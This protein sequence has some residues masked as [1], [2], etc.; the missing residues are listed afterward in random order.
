MYRRVAIACE[1]STTN[2]EKI[3]DPLCR[4]TQVRS[5]VN[6]YVTN[7]LMRVGD[8]A[9]EGGGANISCIRRCPARTLR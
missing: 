4:R 9:H 5:P 7:L 1:P 8:F 3:F 6:G 2:R